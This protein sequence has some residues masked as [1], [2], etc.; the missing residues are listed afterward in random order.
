MKIM[1]SCVVV[2]KQIRKERKWRRKVEKVAERYSRSAKVKINPFFFLNMGVI[3]HSSAPPLF[4][5]W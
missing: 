4:A 1:R 5:N 2:G 3:F